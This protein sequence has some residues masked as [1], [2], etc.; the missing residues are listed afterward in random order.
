[1]YIFDQMLLLF[2]FLIINRVLINSSRRV[3]K[4]FKIFVQ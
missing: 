2:F 1:M 3:E 4:F